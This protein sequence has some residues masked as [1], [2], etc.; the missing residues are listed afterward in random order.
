[1][2]KKSREFKDTNT[3]SE[4]NENIY[5]YIYVAVLWPSIQE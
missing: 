1:M 5:K 3:A 4:R 2:I